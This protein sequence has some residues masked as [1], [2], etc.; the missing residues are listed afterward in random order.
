MHR[1]PTSPS[2]RFPCLPSGLQR[3][4]VYASS[5][6]AALD[7]SAHAPSPVRLRLR[8]LPFRP[9]QHRQR[10]F[11]VNANGKL[12]DIWRLVAC[13]SCDRTS[14]ITVHD[15]VPVR[16]L[17]PILPKGYSGNSS[18]PWARTGA[19]GKVALPRT[20][21]CGGPLAV[22]HDRARTKVR[23]GPIPATKVNAQVR[24][25]GTGRIERVT[26]LSAGIRFAT[27]QAGS[28][29]L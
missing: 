4:H 26:A 11:R 24:T 15:R 23:A 13:V 25:S 22:A 19:R 9:R 28:A 7:R 17:D 5:Y 29:G 3:D 27:A 12:L 16:R 6:R 20:A 2:A 21:S 1:S 18:R 8:P 10:K 14:K